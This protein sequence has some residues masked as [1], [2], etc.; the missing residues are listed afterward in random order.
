M[1]LAEVYTARLVAGSPEVAGLAKAIDLAGGAPLGEYG[2][3]LRLGAA[4]KGLL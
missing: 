4:Q 3:L 2:S 1:A